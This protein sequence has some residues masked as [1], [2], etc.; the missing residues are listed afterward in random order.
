MSDRASSF[1][2]A[3][4]AA[5][6]A[7][8]TLALQH[9]P[10][11]GSLPTEFRIFTAGKVVTEKGTF[12]FDAASAKA[13]MSEYRTHGNE[14]MIDYDH[15]SL[16]ATDARDPAMAGKAA[17]WCALE[18]RGGELWAVNVRW[19]DPAA[20]A[21]RA[22][23]WRYMSPAF[24]V[25]K[26]KITSLL[27]VALTNI[28]ATRN[29]TPLVAA[30]RSGL[31]KKRIRVKL[32]KKKSFLILLDDAGDSADVSADDGGD[33]DVTAD[34]SD[35]TVAAAASALTDPDTVAAIA[36]AL[37]LDASASLPDVLAAMK[38]A[39]KSFTDAVS[40]D[41]A[42]K[43]PPPMGDMSASR[44][45][46]AKDATIVRANVLRK[47]AK[48]NALDALA[49]I[50]TWKESHVSLAKQRTEMANDKAAL[51]AT[52]LHRCTVELV[53]LNGFTPAIAWDDPLEKTLK[54]SRVMLALGI[55]GAKDLI[56]KLKGAPKASA[57]RDAGEVI[58]GKADGELSEFEVALCS[59]VSKQ[60][61]KTVEV[62]RSEYL[63]QRV[64]TERVNT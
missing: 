20:A 27:N 24:S 53:K 16:S 62:V 5:R 32:G 47:T 43:A 44:I 59:R 35:G 7:W 13:L 18:L 30:S 49:E 57:L 25:E 45:S 55:A 63:E 17:G 26:N 61:G 8:V 12:T 23:E 28:P 1:V 22:K 42:G 50:D 39:I 58:A 52:E 48:D 64:R 60:S 11:D 38:A 29:L 14:I 6:A 3:S 21:L 15:A 56:A 36:G 54:P 10:V 51:E 34:D 4:R 2:T 37:G 9:V 41:D 31:M 40:G 46:A 33:A 19:S